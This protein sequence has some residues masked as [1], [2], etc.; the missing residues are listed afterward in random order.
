MNPVPDVLGQPA[1]PTSVPP[2]PASTAAPQAPAD[3]SKAD[4]FRVCVAFKQVYL[5]VNG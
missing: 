4:V 1:A 5:E 2:V 3:P